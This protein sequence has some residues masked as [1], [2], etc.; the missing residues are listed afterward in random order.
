MGAPANKHLSVRN[1]GKYI[2]DD[3]SGLT[4]KNP[5]YKS[6]AGRGTDKIPVFGMLDRETRKVRAQIIPQIKRESL[7]N[8]IL[9]NIE[10]RSTICSDS[11][12][13]YKG[14]KTLEFVHDTVNHMYENVR[15]EVHTNGIENF[16]SLLKRGLRG[17]YVAVEPLHLDAYVAEQVF[18]YNNRATKGNP[19]TD[20]DRF[21]L[22]VSQISG[23]RLTY[24]ELAGKVGETEAF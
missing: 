7:M 22:A 16:W 3:K 12:V 10:K 1:A 18:R 19:L 4:V 2:V 13:D 9:N 21:A 14:L 23:K 20:V 11:L 24:A 5:N 8:A 17:T 15:G 6:T